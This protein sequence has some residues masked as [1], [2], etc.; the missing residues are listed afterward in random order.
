[1]T[2][3]RTDE[4]EAVVSYEQIARKASQDVWSAL[5]PESEAVVSNLGVET[6]ILSAIRKAIAR[7]RETWRVAYDLDGNRVEAMI[8]EAERQATRYESKIADRDEIIAKLH[9]EISYAAQGIGD[10]E[11]SCRLAELNSTI[12]QAAEAARTEQSS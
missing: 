6:I 11:R 1:M 2:T 9:R 8:A 4:K 7:E 12:R 10:A 3:S 5:N